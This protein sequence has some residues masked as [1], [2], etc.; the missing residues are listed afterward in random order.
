MNK[1]KLLACLFSIIP[2]LTTLIVNAQIPDLVEL[3]VP[4]FAV[5]KEDV[6]FSQRISSNKLISFKAKG[7]TSVSDEYWFEATGKQLKVGVN[8]AIS[9]P[10]A[11]VRLSG[12]QA[13]DKYSINAKAI[14]PNSVQLFKNRKKLSTPFSQ[15][16]SQQEFATANIFPN[17]SAMKLNSELGNGIFTLKVNDNLNDYQR[18]IVNVKEKNTKHK[19]HLSLAKQSYM[20]GQVIDFRSKLKETS[21]NKAILTQGT[22]LAYIKSPSGERQSLRFTEND[23]QFQFSMPTNLAPTKRGQ[24][25]ELHVE[26]EDKIDGLKVKR[27]A[28]VAFALV[29]PTARIE[30]VA[31]L[32]Q[33]SF[34]IDAIDERDARDARDARTQKPVVPSFVDINLLVASEGRY[35][36]SAMVHGTSGKKLSV[37]FML[38]RSAYYLTPGRHT[39][40]LQLDTKIIESSG[41]KAPY[42][43]KSIRLMDQSRMTLLQQM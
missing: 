4:D 6:H 14:N 2:L 34:K 16:V 20:Q 9:T 30:E 22:L 43:F 13:K 18:Y 28:K 27:N 12:K 37:P 40:K 8:L 38:S 42:I 26:T 15:K 41:L 10:G 1:L 25:F 11:L 23:N 32:N 19:L 29:Q 35:E 3:N 33:T 24:L 31:K 21:S 36:V 17:S 39:V 7:Y 5:E